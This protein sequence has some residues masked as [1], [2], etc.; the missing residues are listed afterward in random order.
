MLEHDCITLM[1]EYRKMPES[2]GDEILKDVDTFW[3]W[4]QCSDF[5]AD[6]SELFPKIVLQ[7]GQ[8][9]VTGES[10]GGF[11]AVYSWL[12]Q[13]DLRIKA[14]YL[15]Y[16]MLRSYTR[17]AGND[18]RE[19]TISEQDVQKY[20]KIYCDHIKKLKEDGLIIPRMS[21]SPPQGMD[22]AYV[23]SS[24][25]KDVMYNGKPVSISYWTWW[26]QQLDILDRLREI[27]GQLATATPTWSGKAK[28]PPSE[29]FILPSARHKKPTYAPEIFISHG[30]EDKNC[31]IQDSRDFKE[32]VEQLVEDAKIEIEEVLG[33][34]HGFDYET[35][36]TEK[37]NDWLKKL[38]K[39]VGMAWTG[40]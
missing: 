12:S 36:E 7:R 16:P 15:Q 23:L 24:A 13:P 38:M 37:D 26:F 33:A 14:M 18:Y 17:N 35:D 30:V 6:L 31:P 29:V 28:S 22:M 20:A 3:D 34:K 39:S 27:T 8:P 32:L 1:P 19:V 21:E 4:V 5:Y 40:N 10:A 25:K 2:H 9:L 11:L